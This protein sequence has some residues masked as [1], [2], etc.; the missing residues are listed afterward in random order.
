MYNAH[1]HA[2]INVLQL[3]NSLPFYNVEP[4]EGT[5]MF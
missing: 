2:N 1:V 5:A 4:E 3:L